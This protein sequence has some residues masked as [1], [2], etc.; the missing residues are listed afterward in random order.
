MLSARP[1]AGNLKTA[2]RQQFMVQA[3]L[4]EICGHILQSGAWRVFALYC[5]NTS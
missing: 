3:Q 2:E 4:L 1:S 5:R